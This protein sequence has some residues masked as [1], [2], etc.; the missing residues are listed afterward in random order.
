MGFIT[1]SVPF[2]E[3]WTIKMKL[4]KGR[5]ENEAGRLRK[6]I[7]TYDLLDSLQISYERVDHE[8]LYTMEACTVV[9]RLL[10]GTVCKN[11]FLCNRQ[12][13]KYYLLMMP[14]D[15]T[16][17]TK[18]L[19]SRI[20][21]ARLSF[22]PQEDMEKLMNLTPGSVTVMGLMYDQENQVQLLV[23]EDV[24]AGEYLGCHPCVNTSSIRLRTADVF[25]KF[26]RAVH[27]DATSVHLTVP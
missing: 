6:E 3:R 9:D 15:K 7:E 14:G 5:P 18:E 23:D 21:S 4:E 13:S 11:L 26:L 16:F 24:L 22:A 10:Q 25:D 8:A 17:K 2:A 19:S 20:G 1:P 27:H 12:K